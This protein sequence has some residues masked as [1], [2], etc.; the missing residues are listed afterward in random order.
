MMRWQI[1]RDKGAEEIDEHDMPTEPIPYEP[2][3]PSAPT[4]S[5]GAISPYDEVVPVPPPLEQPFP[6]QYIPVMPSQAAP[7]YVPGGGVYPVLPAPPAQQQRRKGKRSTGGTIGGEMGQSQPPNNAQSMRAS[8]SRHSSVPTLVKLFFIAVRLL[9]AVQLVLTILRW[10]DN[11]L[12]VSIVY[13]LSPVFIWP[14]S[15][16]IAQIH[17]P[18]TLWQ[19]IYTLLAIV[20]YSVLSRI[21]VGFLKAIKRYR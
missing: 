5:E 16:L 3:P 7:A 4:V 15:I 11:A 2:V 17:L 9:L 12:W 21:L 6:R 19:E 14:V 10:P 1:P 13:A 18:F 20:F 8:Q